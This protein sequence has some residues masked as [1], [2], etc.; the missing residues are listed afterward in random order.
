LANDSSG[1]FYADDQLMYVTRSGDRTVVVSADLGPLRTL[2]TRA[3]AHTPTWE[4]LEAVLPRFRQVQNAPGSTVGPPLVLVLNRLI[5]L[6]LD[7]LAA[8]AQALVTFV[9]ASVSAETPDSQVVANWPAGVRS[10]LSLLSTTPPAET[11]THDPTGV[12]VGVEVEV[13]GLDV[14]IVV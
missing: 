8:D 2:S 3:P 9:G 13:G 6:S 4:L 1:V 5:G 12:G 14:R 10:M 7:E 11:S